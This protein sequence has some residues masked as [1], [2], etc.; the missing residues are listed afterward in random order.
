MPTGIFFVKNP[1]FLTILMQLHFLPFFVILQY[2]FGK[3]HICKRE[4]LTV[5]I[6]F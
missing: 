2:L 6:D 3:A 4:R 1:Y 5:L